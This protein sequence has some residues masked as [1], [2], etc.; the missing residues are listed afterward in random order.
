MARASTDQ[1]ITA[2]IEGGRDEGVL[3]VDGR[4]VRVTHLDRVLFPRTG[5]TKGDLI[6]YYAAIS[7][8]M[9]PHLRNR[10]L[11]MRRFPAGV[12]EDG[13]WEKQCPEFRPDWVST[14]TIRSKSSRRGKVDYCLVNDLP[15]LVWVANLACIEL[16]VSLARAKTRDRPAS[17]VFDL[18]PGPPADLMDCAEISLLIRDTLERQGL[19]SLAKVSGSKGLQVYVPLNRKARYGTTGEFAHSLARTFEEAMPDRVVSTMRKK[20]RPGKVL[21]D[22]S[23]NSEH[24]TTVA[25]Y[26][27]RAKERPSVSA[28]VSWEEIEGAL[29][30]GDPA[31]LRFGPSVAVNRSS[32]SGDLFE[33]VLKLRQ[34][35]P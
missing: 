34:S 20:K 1:P 10:P 25:V 15:T 27:I 21:I 33:A 35:L 28:P 30:S 16:H 6:D 12:D 26:S 2:R 23:Q 22:W 11:S 8:V 32:A 7:P 29:D 18:D 13:F 31:S 9:L 5:F 4:E 14:A 24:K 19:R 3:K 17:I